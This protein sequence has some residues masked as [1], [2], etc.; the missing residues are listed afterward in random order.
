[1][2]FQCREH[3]QGTAHSLLYSGVGQVDFLFQ[4]FLFSLFQSR[5]EHATIF[6]LPFEFLHFLKKKSQLSVASPAQ[7]KPKACLGF[8][9]IHIYWTVFFFFFFCSEILSRKLEGVRSEA[10]LYLLW[11]SDILPSMWKYP[12]VS[13]SVCSCKAQLNNTSA[14]RVMNLCVNQLHVNSPQ[15]VCSAD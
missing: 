15:N 12:D 10:G 14:I 6:L 7:D 13:H 4:I 8:S 3:G 9:Q 2:H 11:A 1:M 5:L